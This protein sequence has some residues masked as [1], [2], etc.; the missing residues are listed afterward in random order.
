MKKRNI[1]M[2]TYTKNGEW[3][4]LCLNKTHVGAIF[5]FTKTVHQTVSV[6]NKIQNSVVAGIASFWYLY[7][8][9]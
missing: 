4:Y 3:L 7:V 6:A 9:S 1:R 8:L 2:N 5:F